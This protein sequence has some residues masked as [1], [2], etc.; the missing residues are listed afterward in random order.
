MRRL[1]RTLAANLG[2][3]H[4]DVLGLGPDEGVAVRLDDL[5]EAAFS[6]RKP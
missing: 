3:H 4:P 1:P 5:G 6:E 2:R